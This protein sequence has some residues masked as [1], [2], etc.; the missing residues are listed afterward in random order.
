MVIY[1]CCAA[2][3]VLFVLFVYTLRKYERLKA[4]KNK[5]YLQEIIATH[6]KE[7]AALEKNFESQKELLNEKFQETEKTYSEKLRAMELEISQKTDIIKEEL[8]EFYRKR[9]AIVQDTLRARELKEKEN[10]YKIQLPQSDIEDI[11]LLASISQKFNRRELIPK[12]IWD[13]IAS[14]PTQEMIK[15]VAG[16]KEGGIYK[17]TYI[18]TG[19]VYIGRT[20]NFATRFKAHVQTA[21]GMEKAAT[22]TLHTHMKENGFWNYTFEILEECPKEKQNEREKFYIDLYQSKKQ[23]NM[24]GGG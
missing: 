17:I 6:E 8:K 15:R 13:S 21:L 4:D 10:F 7:V 19:E 3:L 1:F 5:K 20:T 16:Q 12:I 18:P 9:E 23:L 11:Q 22:S 14:R 24:K 2:I